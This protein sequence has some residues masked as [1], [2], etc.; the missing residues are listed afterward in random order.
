MRTNQGAE[1]T[2]HVERIEPD[3]G[4]SAGWQTQRLPA[5]ADAGGTPAT[6]SNRRNNIAALALIIIGVLMAL[7]RFMPEQGEMTGGLVLLTIASGFLFF[8]F[9]RRI[10]ALLIPGSILA[11]LG[12]GVPLARVTNGVSVLWGLALGFVS[13]LLIGRTLFNVQSPW[14]LFPAVPLFCVG[15]IVAIA[16]LPGY[17]AGGMIWFPLLLIA[18]GL[19]LGWSRRMA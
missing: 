12:L 8:A 2:E 9:W 17:L 18:A 16:N 10:Y 19:Y 4:S 13:I 14:P 3:A 1:N 5:P 11:G 7:G 15:V 6:Y